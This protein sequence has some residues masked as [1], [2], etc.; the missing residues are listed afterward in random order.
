MVNP[1]QSEMC[2][3]SITP[4]WLTTLR[5]NKQ[6]SNQTNKQTKTVK[7][8]PIQQPQPQQGWQRAGKKESTVSNNNII[9]THDACSHRAV[10][11][12]DCGKRSSP[13]PKLS[14]GPRSLRSPLDVRETAPSMMTYIRSSASGFFQHTGIGRAVGP[15]GK[16]P[17]SACF[18]FVPI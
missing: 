18:K 12:C 2:F 11:W 16:P 4:I 10:V 6:T 15:P 3:R 5:V 9:F 17:E 13:S 8:Q 14:P 1:T 7:P